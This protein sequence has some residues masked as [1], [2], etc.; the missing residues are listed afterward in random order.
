M[1]TKTKEAPSIKL[2]TKKAG[3]FKGRIVPAQPK[4]GCNPYC[5]PLCN[6]IGAPPCVPF[7]CNPIK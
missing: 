2:V 4:P 5:S 7:P 6:P 3:K 1:Q